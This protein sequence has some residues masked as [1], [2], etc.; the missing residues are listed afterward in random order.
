M[1]K[2]VSKILAFVLSLVMLCTSVDLSAF[3]YLTDKDGYLSVD[4]DDGSLT[5]DSSWEE[6]FPTGTFAFKNDAVNITEDDKEE[7][8]I[9]IYRLGGTKGKATAYVAVTPLVEQLDEE[10]KEYIYANGAC[11]TDINVKAED[12]VS[13]EETAGL[14]QLDMTYEINT[15]EKNDQV[16]LSLKDVE[17]QYIRYFWHVYKDGK[18][19]LIDNKEDKELTI[20]KE[21][22][23]DNNY[24]CVVESDYEL[25]L[26]DS[27]KDIEEASLY[28][29]KNSRTI[30]IPAVSEGLS[31]SE[32]PLDTNNPYKTSFFEVDFEENEWVKDIVVSANDDLENESVEISDFTIYD[33]EGAEFTEAAN[34]C[35]LTVYDDEPVIPSKMGIG[36]KEVRVDKSEGTA[37]IRVKRT[38][39]LQYVSSV[40]FET[41]DATAKA[42]TDYAATKGIASFS[43]GFDY[44]DIQIPLINDK[45]KSDKDVSLL[46]YNYYWQD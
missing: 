39:G 27:L 36:I 20:S 29:N 43:G 31:Y 9:T 14:E 4:T 38:E 44:Y 28:V 30:Q 6:K 3:A 13:Q 11:N 24:I 41:A 5:E 18:W 37:T 1:R 35:A 22:Y 32:I 2:K 16:T 26:S 33:A 40:D 23:A 7:Q 12:S 45:K 46:E 19:S 42:G 21:E 17:G 15:H 25:S 10:G 34:R 8:K